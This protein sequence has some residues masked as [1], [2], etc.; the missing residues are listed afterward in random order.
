[1]TQIMQGLAAAPGIGIGA[2]HLYRPGL[3]APIAPTAD[4]AAIDP[5]EEWQTFLTAHAHVDAELEELEAN[6][7]SFVGEI[8]AAHR[9]ILQDRTL[10]DWVQAA[11]YEEHL[12]AAAATHKVISNLAD[13]FRSFEDEYFA[14]RAIDILDLGQR[15]LTQLGEALSRPQLT[16]LPPQTI[17]VAEDLTL[18]DLAQLPVDHVV[19]IALAYSTPTAHSAILARSQ[20]IPLVCALGPSLLHLLPGQNAVVDGNEGHFLVNIDAAVMERYSSEQQEYLAA[21]VLALTHA[22]KPAYTRDGV[23]VPI[24]AN[25]NSPQEVSQSRS[26]GADGIGLLRT[27]YLFQGRAIPPSYD[28][29]RATYAEFITQV[30]RQLTVRALDA[31]GDK[32]VSYI[33][34]H[35]EDN[36]FLGRRGIRLLLAE[37]EL[38][39]VQYC[40]LQAAAHAAQDPAQNPAQAPVE[41]RFMLPM[42]STA[43]EILSVRSILNATPPHANF[44]CDTTESDDLP[45]LKLGIMIEVPSAAL[46][47]ASL[48][49]L[50]DF[51][52]IGTNDLAQ[53]VLASD[54]TN[55][56]VANL[57]DPLHPAVLHLIYQTCIA[58]QAAGK[59]VSLCGEIA[60]DPL[61]TPL[62]L[63]LGVNELS[64]PLFAV[65]IIKETVRDLDMA[66]CRQLATA[67]LACSSAAA[68]RALLA[69]I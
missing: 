59:P 6:P 17:L 69:T 58:A 7:N 39:R 44:D 8:F 29:Q 5:Q 46:I 53:Y 49:P 23:H 57:A 54:R 67:A 31:G 36:P 30:N 15:L 16:Q 41:V 34:H 28:E 24:L 45:H 11:I 37:P 18:S 63:G 19:G 50:V 10:L 4:E 22:H 25:A 9:A 66:H 65:P 26:M 3:A 40:A 13:L 1:M 27:E 33:V 43:E 2:L 38:L 47:A 56:I 35:R 51:F 32:P 21:G 48:A 61:A 42:I 64:V 52:S 55:S 62:L 12:S 14:G 68:V 20:G 60:G